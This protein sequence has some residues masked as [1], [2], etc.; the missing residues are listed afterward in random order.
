MTA[1]RPAAFLDRDGTLIVEVDY[2]ADPD[3]V[4]LIP[5]ATGAIRAAHAAGWLVVIIT[6]QSGIARGRYSEDQYAAVTRRLE[7]LLAAA[8]APV[9]GIRHCPHHPDFTGVCDCRKPAPGMLLESSRD[10]HIDLARSIVIGDKRSDLGAAVA[11]GARPVLVRTGYGAATEAAGDLPPG[12]VVIDSIA[13]LVDG[14]RFGPPP[15][16]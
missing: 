8:D 9:D 7:E 14:T 3:G 16:R 15:A 13:D 1:P 4:E 10:L 5:G 12:T 11:V 6:N 2:L